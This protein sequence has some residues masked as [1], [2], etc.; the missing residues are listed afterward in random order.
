MED[1]R[2]KTVQIYL[3][4]GNA[5]SIR[6]AE[7]T[8][9]TIQAVQIPRQKL[10]AAGKREEVR[11]VG[12]YFLFGDV[13]DNASKPP[14]YIGEAENCFQRIS[15]HHQRKDFWTTAVSITS[16]T[17]NFTKAHAQR[18]E[19]DCIRAAQ[20]AERFRLEN[21]QMPA[22]PHIPEAM[23]AQLRDNFG[24]IQT[25]LSMLGYPILDPIPK[26]EDTD[27]GGT[28]LYCEGN[29]A[30]A[31]G[32]YTEDGLVVFEGSIARLETQPSASET[33]ERRRENLRDDGVLEQEGDHLVFRENHVFNSPSA[34][35]GVV[36]GRNGNGWYGWKDE[37]EQNL[38]EL[39]RQ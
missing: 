3:P 22:E 8:S 24:T 18:L 16:K 23:L 12:V 13:D 4:D 6:V 26:E 29:G 21:T 9:R 33:I 31:T 14:A 19:H 5:R 11:R 30:E 10:E 17:R 2:P 37:N 36:M 28:K 34:A 1:S 39:E 35:V 25:L 27:D 38:H 20:G 15:G 7:I 32:E